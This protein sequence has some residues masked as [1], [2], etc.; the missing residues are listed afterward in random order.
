MALEAVTTRL[1]REM[2]REVERLAEKEKVDRSELIRRLLDF[3]LRQKRV[4]EALE[5]Y[6]DGSVTL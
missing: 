4:D 1:P 5:A 6:R 2:L 3:A